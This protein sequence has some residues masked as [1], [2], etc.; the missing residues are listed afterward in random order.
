MILFHD[1]VDNSSEAILKCLFWEE[2]A[3][4]PHVSLF[5][6]RKKKLRTIKEQGQNT[7]EDE[8]IFVSYFLQQKPSVS[9][10]LLK[11]LK[12]RKIVKSAICLGLYV[13]WEFQ[14]SSVHSGT[15]LGRSHMG[16]YRC[17]GIRICVLV[18]TLKEGVSSTLYMVVTESS[19]CLCGTEALSHW[20]LAGICSHQW[21]FPQFPAAQASVNPLTLWLLTLR[22]TGAFSLRFLFLFVRSS[23]HV[24]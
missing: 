7:H 2:R 10:L 6:T 20:L 24:T 1:T 22:L 8:S 11:Y 23:Y 14:V 5:R 4:F 18:Q 21:C 16:Q 12:R 17:L 13:S 19:L 15:Q 3:I 9:R